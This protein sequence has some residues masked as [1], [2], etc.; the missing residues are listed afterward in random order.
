MTAVETESAPYRIGLVEDHLD[1]MSSALS[2][3]FQPYPE[4]ELVA[5]GRTVAELLAITDQLDLVIL[6]L[7]GLP[8][9]STPKKNVRA[10]KTA[11]ISNILV[12]T[13]RDSRYLVQEAGRAGVLGV[14]TKTDP[15]ATLIE[16]VRLAVNG[17]LAPSVDWAAALDADEGLIPQLT[18]REREVLAMY[19]SGDTAKDIAAQLYLSPETIRKH[20]MKIK[21]KY[22]EAGFEIHKKSEMRRVAQRDGYIHD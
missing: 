8:D 4:L 1:V 12:Y 11:G 14:I 19:A 17:Q 16:A 5:A 9:K 10:L 20:V 3:F 2:G 22:T 13:S 7:Q 18:P 21:D 15:R 6:D